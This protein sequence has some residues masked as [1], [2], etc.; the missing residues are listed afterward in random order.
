MAS[1]SVLGV[2]LL[3]AYFGHIY[4]TTTTESAFKNVLEDVS[5]CKESCERTYPVHT[6][7]EVRYLMIFGWKS[8]GLCSFVHSFPFYCIV[9]L[10]NSM[11]KK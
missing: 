8:Q 2:I 5:S 3:L 6:Y 1:G 11:S 7:P 10:A 4:A 9:L